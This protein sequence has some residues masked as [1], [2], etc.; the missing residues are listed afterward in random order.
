MPDDDFLPEKHPLNQYLSELELTED[1]FLT[2]SSEVT[3]PTYPDQWTI[4]TTLKKELKTSLPNCFSGLV[5][6]SMVYP[7]EY[8]RCRILRTTCS[9]RLHLTDDETLIK[10][11]SIFHQ[12]RLEN[13]RGHFMIFL[14]FYLLMPLGL[15][16]S[17]SMLFWITS[18]LVLALFLISMFFA[19]WMMLVNWNLCHVAQQLSLAQATVRLSMGFLQDFE[20][21]YTFG[22]AGKAS[23]QY[24]LCLIKRVVSCLRLYVFQII[25]IS[26]A[27][28]GLPVFEEFPAGIST[29]QLHELRDNLPQES[30]GVASLSDCKMFREISTLL[31]SE[32]L[33]RVTGL[34][35]CL[36]I[37]PFICWFQLGLLL[38]KWTHSLHS[39]RGYLLELDQLRAAV[40]Q[41]LASGDTHANSCTESSMPPTKYPGEFDAV[42]KA[43][44]SLYMHLLVAIS[45]MKELT[46]L[47]EQSMD[48]LSG[49]DVSNVLSRLRL[50]LDAC[51]NLNDE[52]DR[53]FSPQPI[54]DNVRRVEDANVDIDMVT[55][56][57]PRKNTNCK[58]LE[59]R[60]IDPE[61]DVLEDIALGDGTDEKQ[62]HEVT[63]PELETGLNTVMPLHSSVI[64]ELRVA[65]ASRRLAMQEREQRALEKRLRSNPA[66]FAQKVDPPPVACERVYDRTKIAADFSNE[67]D[68]FIPPSTANMDVDVNLIEFFPT[69]DQER[70]HMNLSQRQS[71][72]RGSWQIQSAVRKRLRHF[73]QIS[74]TES[75]TDMFNQNGSVHRPGTTS[76]ETPVHQNPTKQFLADPSFAAALLAQRRKVG[77]VEEE[78]FFE[79]GT[80]PEVLNC[81]PTNVSPKGPTVQ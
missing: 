54:E 77:Y 78:S 68:Q 58:S 48:A 60:D 57:R 10:S 75:Q 36:P 3:P 1:R 81:L 47:L 26:A 73:R 8:L 11:F 63:G 31:E 51:G 18:C 6:P 55:F 29:N 39:L 32:L 28:N 50:Q 30:D 19:I 56:D 27:F 34:V 16:Q 7:A 38:R 66:S 72:H 14:A 4:L 22:A 74:A 80:G 65:I 79:I 9:S 40:E 25:D 37:H 5:F 45:T 67:G 23:K 24:N 69:L 15:I 21:H 13:T 59:A 76:T 61:D 46:D 52:L 2:S 42:R 20:V 53:L 70:S 44:R 64:K 33:N 62:D 12:N 49:D 71:K 35:C 43:T 17:Y 41:G